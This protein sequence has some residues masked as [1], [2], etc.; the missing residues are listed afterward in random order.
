MI[1]HSNATINFPKKLV[2]LLYAWLFAHIGI[3]WLKKLFANT[4]NYGWLT[5][6]V[7]KIGLVYCEQVYLVVRCST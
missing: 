1:L 7:T 6:F 4:Q 5:P 3:F 2:P